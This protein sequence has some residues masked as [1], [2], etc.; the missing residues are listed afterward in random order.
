ML[1]SRCLCLCNASMHLTRLAGVLPFLHST[2]HPKTVASVF[3][4]IRMKT[5]IKLKRSLQ[6]E[7][8]ETSG[9]LHC[10]HEFHTVCDLNPSNSPEERTDLNVLTLKE[11]SFS[12]GLKLTSVLIKLAVQT[13]RHTHCLPHT[14]AVLLANTH[15]TPTFTYTVHPHTHTYTHTLTLL[16]PWVTLMWLCV[17]VFA[18]LALPTL[19]S[20]PASRV[21]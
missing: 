9:W 17:C 10:D 3:S 8:S 1:F 4:K 7:I 20:V 12:Q 6:N 15:C 18:S 2:L 13:H 11:M 16:L 5:A 14:H 19:A 21:S